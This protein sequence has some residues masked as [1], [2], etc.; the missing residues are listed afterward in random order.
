M[1]R[2]LAKSSFTLIVTCLVLLG[3]QEVYIRHRDN[4][5]D[6]EEMVRDFCET[7]GIGAGALQA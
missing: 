2:F 7:F 1:L 6:P 4:R 3:G 5:L